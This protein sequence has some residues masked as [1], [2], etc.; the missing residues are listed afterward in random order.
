VLFA[1]PLTPTQIIP[2]F[3]GAAAKALGYLFIP[4]P[5][6]PEVMDFHKDMKYETVESELHGAHTNPGHINLITAE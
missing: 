6:V 4:G 1:A 5:H 3:L 2:H